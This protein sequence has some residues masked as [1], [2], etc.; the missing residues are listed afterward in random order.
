MSQSNIVSDLAFEQYAPL[1]IDTQDGFYYNLGAGVTL[2]P[3]PTLTAFFLVRY[4][5]IGMDSDNLRFVP[6]T[7]GIQF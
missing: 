2:K 3:M 4:L 1:L 6:I 7:F 5:E